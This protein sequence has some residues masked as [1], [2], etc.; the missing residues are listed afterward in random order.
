MLF[1]TFWAL[2]L[3]LTLSGAV[4]AFISRNKM[5]EQLGD[6]SAKSVFKASLYGIISS[7]CSY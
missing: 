5:K 4:Q 1:H 2:I 6:D 7:G 3:G